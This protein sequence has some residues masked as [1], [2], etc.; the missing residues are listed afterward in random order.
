MPRNLNEIENSLVGLQKPQRNCTNMNSAS[1]LGTSK[2][3]YVDHEG[4]LP[5]AGLAIC[6]DVG[7][8]TGT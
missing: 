4:D 5:G 1:D 2:S 3:V 7:R 6:V 8:I